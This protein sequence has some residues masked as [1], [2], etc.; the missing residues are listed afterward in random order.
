MAS[1]RPD[2]RRGLW[3]L[4]DRY[5]TTFGILGANLLLFLF[6]GYR[7]G[8]YPIDPELAVQLGA[9]LYTLVPQEPWRL[10]TSA[11]LHYHPVHFALNAVALFVLG[12]VLEVHFGSARLFVLYI[13]FALA[14]S[15]ASALWHS[16]LPLPA[17]SAGASGALFGLILLGYLY[18]RS[19]PDRLG[20]LAEHLQL[21]IVAGVVISFVVPSDTGIDV[22]AHFGGAAAGAVAGYLVHPRP[23]ED[24]SRAWSVAA[25]ILALATVGSFLI[26]MVRLREVAG[27]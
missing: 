13:L 15:T 23:G 22:A 9:N 21:W 14:G 25:L 19:V 11:F 17:A 12:R 8:N 5:P 27:A 4:L 10:L 24:V 1:D 2:L 6:A 18:A 26:V 16:Y 3:D 20:T 7:Q